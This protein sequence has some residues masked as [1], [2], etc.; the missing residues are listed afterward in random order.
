MTLRSVRN[1]L[2]ARPLQPEQNAYENDLTV[3]SISYLFLVQ[4]SDGRRPQ[5]FMGRTASVLRFDV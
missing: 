1:H 2:S 3:G 5:T 4:S